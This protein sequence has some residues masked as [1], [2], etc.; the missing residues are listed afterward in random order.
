MTFSRR[1]APRGVA[2]AIS[3]PAA[4]GRPPG[5]SP[6]RRRGGGSAGTAAAAVAAV[7]WLGGVAV[8]LPG[9]T[10]TAAP[11]GPEP[12]LLEQPDGSP[13]TVF[14]RGDER[15]HWHEDAGGRAI[16]RDR[17]SGW[18]VYAREEGGRL[19]PTSDRV[20]VADPSSLGLERPDLAKVRRTAL[21]G[22]ERAAPP[23]AAFPAAA[24]GSMLNLVILTGFS[25]LPFTYPTAD[26]DD[27]FN[28]PGYGAG[29][30]QGSVRDYYQ[31]I[32]YG[33][34][35]IV[36]HV[37]PPVTILSGY[38]T[39]GA[40]DAD[41]NDVGV[42]LMVLEALAAL[43]S[44]GFDFSTM[45]GNGDGRLDCL[46]IIHAGRGEEFAGNDPDYVWSQKWNL[47]NPL[48]MDGVEIQD[49][50]TEPEQYG[51]DSDPGSWS[52]GRI[53]VICHETGHF[54]GLPDLYDRDGGSKG[55]GDFCLM[56][57]GGWNGGQFLPAHM[58]AWCKWSLGFLTPATIV[59]EGTYALQDAETHPAALRLSGP[60]PNQET[61][62][63]ENRQGIGFDAALPGTQRGLLIWHIDPFAG[64]NDDPADY[65]VDLEEASGVQH[66]QLNLN[67]GDDDDY[68][69][70]GGGTA[71]T[72]GS[73]PDNLRYDGESLSMDV[74][75]VGPTGPTMTFDVTI[76][77]VWVDFAHGGVE[78]GLYLLP[79]NTL[80]EGVD[81]CPAGGRV[82]IKG[83]S[84][85]ETLAIDK[86]LKL[87][88]PLGAAVVGQ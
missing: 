87:S 63:I 50:H 42:R 30:A 29:G 37:E 77:D 24:A 39:C 1:E 12:A 8:V 72:T 28:L 10:A 20:G 82:A 74:T 13:V 78:A 18:W 11:A 5:G 54:I 49:F 17:G 81:A 84:S 73:T 66:L 36:S 59:A 65:L 43:D 40:N 44:R 52:M 64:S 3:P 38:A 27:L 34:F 75:S 22:D 79:F 62:L 21:A 33:G 26:F 16:L 76:Y 7:L 4:G 46:T 70:A 83:G 69:R 68:W 55:V 32:S 61:F 25:D 2:A 23:K 85:P 19:V 80:A 45:D 57:G 51:F 31:E 6:L 53:G 41:G 71:F 88:A 86:A 67:E 9:E 14:L 58:S 56:G 60:H 47:L 15:F 35:T 48:T